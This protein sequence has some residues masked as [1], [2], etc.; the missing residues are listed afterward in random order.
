M[1]EHDGH[2]ELERTVESIIIGRRHRQHPGEDIESLMVSIKKLGL[3][4]P[5]TITPDGLL[6]CGARRLEAV[7]RLGWTTLKVWVRSGISDELNRLL[8]QQDENEERK[9]LDPLEQAALFRELRRLMAEDAARRQAATQFGAAED[10]AG[11]GAA[12]AAAP[13]RGHGDSR[14]RAAEAVTG[15]ASYTFLEQIS[16]IERIAADRSMPTSVRRIAEAELIDIGNGADVKP[17]YERV[18]AAAELIA[19][20]DTKSSTGPLSDDE[21]DALSSDAMD[22]VRQKRTRGGHKRRR[23][24]QRSSRRSIRAFL[25]TWGDLDGW[26]RYYDPNEIGTQLK[27]SEWEMFE[28]V[29]AETIAFADEA[30]Q[31]RATPHPASS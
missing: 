24:K 23:A 3:L 15:K 4:Q 14:R 31:T 26:S 18:V 5:V 17:A 19:A 21:L 7:K 30:R 6:V 1:S 27:N 20:D 11:N 22:R 12:A 29:L 13:Q 16:A 25:L 9:P 28:R 2:I 8:A 10:S